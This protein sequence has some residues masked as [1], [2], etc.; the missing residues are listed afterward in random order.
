MNTLKF[1][2]IWLAVGLVGILIYFYSTTISE[3]IDIF[4]YRQLCVVARN[5]GIEQAKMSSQCTLLSSTILVATIGPDVGIAASI[6]G[7]YIA[8]MV[9]INL[10]VERK[11]IRIS[12]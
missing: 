7:F 9:E 2:Q 8:S 10:L 3:R 12:K 1:L 4:H 5:H 11:T 6:L